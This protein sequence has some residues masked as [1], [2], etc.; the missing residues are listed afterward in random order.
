MTPMAIFMQTIPLHYTTLQC[1]AVSSYS[2]KHQSKTNKVMQKN[3]LKQ[4]LK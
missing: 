3:K 1:T 4:G 2:S